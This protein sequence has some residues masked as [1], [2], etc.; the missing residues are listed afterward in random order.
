MKKNKNYK[1]LYIFILLLLI[2][3][4]I[5]NIFKI[6]ENMN[7]KK[8]ALILFGISYH[9]IENDNKLKCNID[10]RESYENYNEK[11]IKY[12]ND[13]GYDIDVFA[14]TNTI[15]LEIKNEMNKIYN[16]I[17]IIESDNDFPCLSRHIKLTKGINSV[18]NYNKNYDICIMIR[19]DL[20][21]QDE[22][23]NVD[24]NKINIVSKLESPDLIDDNIYI[25]PYSKLKY[26]YDILIETA[27]KH[28][29]WYHG[30]KDELLKVSDIHYIKNEE[31]IDGVGGLSFFKINHHK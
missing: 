4:F 26:L 30:M 9:N 24:Y 18:L 1:L 20:T 10:F 16:P 15:P 5:L 27:P 13:K 7:N 23:N 8:I 25:V 6:R 31:N 11:I 14:S 21:I 29:Y 22:F 3:F 19:F 12:F 17:E 28:N 2:L